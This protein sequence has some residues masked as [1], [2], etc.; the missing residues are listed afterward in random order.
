MTNLGLAHFTATDVDIDTFIAIAAETGCQRISLFVNS[1]NPQ[2]A[3]PLVSRK[4]LAEVKQSLQTHGLE[5]SNIECF[6]L[7]PG[8][9]I[10]SFREALALGRELGAVGTTV[11]LFDSDEGRVKDKL[12]AFCELA[13]TYRLR[14]SI[15]FM[16]MAP[17]WHTLAE[18]VALIEQVDR[19]NLGLCI[20]LLHLIR[21]GGSPEDVA[22]LPEHLVHYVQLCD[23]D[24]LSANQQY[25]TEAGVHR[26]APGEGRFP[27]AALLSAVPPLTPLEIEVPQSTQQPAWER[28]KA[29][30]DATRLQVGKAR[31]GSGQAP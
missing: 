30:V 5:V 23:S 19:H 22:A 31:T 18:T 26:L 1:P 4:N 8:T 7:T 12:T 6:M 14:V 2:A 25:A 16:P 10:E 11:L 21:S 13:A 27:I 20:D 28:V 9:D 15:E 29:I 17:A 24:D 3:I